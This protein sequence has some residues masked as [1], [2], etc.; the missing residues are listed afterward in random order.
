M[1]RW[2]VGLYERERGRW[3]GRRRVRWNEGYRVRWRV[4]D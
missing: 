4:V 2:I 1:W 3:I